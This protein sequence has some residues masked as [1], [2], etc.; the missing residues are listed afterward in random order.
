MR[1][2]GFGFGFG[3][4]FVFG[5]RYSEVRWVG[6][7]LGGQLIGYLSGKLNAYRSQCK[8]KG[9]CPVR[10]QRVCLLPLAPL[11]LHR[12]LYAFIAN[13]RYLHWLRTQLTCPSQW[14]RRAGR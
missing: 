5:V 9:A 8:V 6:M 4:G 7:G 14:S 10:A 3:F 11:T 2:G 12:L 13:E 1:Y